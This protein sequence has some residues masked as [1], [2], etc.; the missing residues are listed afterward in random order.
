[1]SDLVVSFVD[2][3]MDGVTLVFRDVPM[4]LPYMLETE[5]V[6]GRS[7]VYERV[8]GERDADTGAHRYRFVR[9]VFEQ[10][11]PVRSWRPRHWMNPAG[12]DRFA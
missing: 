11:A 8:P 2:G 10:P 9:T 7:H 4:V 6:N 5:T 3:A 12:P 1:M